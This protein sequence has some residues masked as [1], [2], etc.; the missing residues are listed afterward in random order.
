MPVTGMASPGRSGVALGEISDRVRLAWRLGHGPQ[1]GR[2]PR[3][4]RS[5]TWRAN[6][7]CDVQARRLSAARE[8]FPHGWWPHGRATALVPGPR[9]AQGTCR[10]VR[11]GIGVLAPESR[12]AGASFGCSAHAPI[13]ECNPDFSNGLRVAPHVLRYSKVH[14][15][16]SQT[17]VWPTSSI[18]LTM[19]AC[20]RRRTTTGWPPALCC[21]NCGPQSRNLL[22]YRDSQHMGTRHKMALMLQA[23]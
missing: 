6:L 9:R 8:T 13:R 19:S 12:T 7:C 14:T 1:A 16:C 17:L 2:S 20:G 4:V 18:C 22:V 15:S 3:G 10:G 21:G 23:T 5:R 11:G